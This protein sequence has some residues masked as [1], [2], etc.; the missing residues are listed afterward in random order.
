MP[1]HR[2]LQDTLQLKGPT[3]IAQTG[4]GYFRSR[5]YHIPHPRP[6]FTGTVVPRMHDE[7]GSP[8]QGLRAAV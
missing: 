1:K 4:K 6:R 7:Q 5:C 8:T 3:W 2:H